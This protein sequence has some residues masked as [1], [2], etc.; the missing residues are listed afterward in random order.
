MLITES[1]EWMKLMK[2]QQKK[3][4][5]TDT[6]AYTVD[7]V[8]AKISAL[9]REVKYLINKAKMWQPKKPKVT[10]KDSNSTK[11]NNTSKDSEASTSTSDGTASSD[12]ETKSTS[13]E[14]TIPS[15]G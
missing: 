11:S 9:D 12:S 6:P 13:E 10:I 1:V 14:N 3:K 5:P 4:L 7:E 2:E 8:V 15:P